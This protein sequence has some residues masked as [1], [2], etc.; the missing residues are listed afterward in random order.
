MLDYDIWVMI[1]PGV[2]NKN[3]IFECIRLIK[4]CYDSS[5]IFADKASHLVSYNVW[6][7]KTRHLGFQHSSLGIGAKCGG[8]GDNFLE[9]LA[10]E[11][12]FRLPVK[13]LL[14]FKC[15]CKN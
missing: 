2:W 7:K 3:F 15:V 12:L 14:R 4:S 13:S 8:C 5:F 9:D 6:T 10:R 11:I 1:Q